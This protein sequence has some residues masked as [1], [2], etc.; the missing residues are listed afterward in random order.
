MDGAWLVQAT[1]RPGR[2]GG[3]ATTTS[4]YFKKAM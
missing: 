4:V 3:P 2:E 1:T